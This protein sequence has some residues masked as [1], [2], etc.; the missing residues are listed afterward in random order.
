MNCCLFGGTDGREKTF[1]TSGMTDWKNLSALVKRHETESCHVN[2]SA[3]AECY[4]DIQSGTS[5]SINKKMSDSAKITIEKNRHIL[6]KIVEVIVLC[7]KQNIPL[8]GHTE[9]NSNFSAILTTFAKSDDILSAHLASA[10]YNAKYTSPEVQNEI[11]DICSEQIKDNILRSCRSCPFFALMADEATDKATKE[12]LSLCVRFVDGTGAVREEF[13][14]FVECS[15]IKG[16]ELC[17]KILS[18]LQEANLDLLKLRAQCYDGASNMSGKYRGVQALIRER[19]PH[20]NY[21]HCKSHCLNLALVHSSNIPC[22]RTMMATVQDIGFMFGYSAK[23]LAAFTDELS[24][25]AV[26]KEQMDQRQKLRTLCETRWSSRADALATFENAFPVVVHALETLEQDHDG[27]AG[28][29]LHSVLRFDFIVT[30]VVAEHMLNS[31]VNLTNLL[32]K[33]DNDL[34]HAVGEAKVVIQLMNDERNDPE[35]WNA[36]YEK[37]TNIAAEFEIPASR[38]RRAGMQIHRANPAV[39]TVSEYWKIT[40]FNTFID[41]LIQEMETRIVSNEERFVAQYLLPNRLP[42]LLDDMLPS[43]YAAYAPDLENSFEVFSNEVTRWRVRWNIAE[44]KPLRLQVTLKQTSKDLY[45]CIYS[46]LSVLLTMPPT[47]A[48]C[49]RSFS[50]MKRI[51]NYLRSTMNT[52]RLSSLAM[53]H[54]HKDMDVSIDGV[55]NTFA[56][57]KCRNLEFF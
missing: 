38:P 47:S 50:A 28:Q 1:T 22:V 27:K 9:E 29:Y 46:I 30:L 41:H 4:K 44:N 35:V 12:Q 14:G 11:I 33:E 10:H 13:L 5:E 48:T 36:L 23:R 15:S 20:A 34:L 25:D 57:R 3:R 21:V 16:N 55:I 56:S 18:F 53:L 45:P 2:A 49:E 24:R 39:D 37:A 7:A 51:K 6:K 31:T 52:E 19:S 42:D 8:R 26:T 17:T 54:I 40:L 43:I 32:Q